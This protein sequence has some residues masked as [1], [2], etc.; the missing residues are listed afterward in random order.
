MFWTVL[1]IWLITFT[2]AAFLAADY[3]LLKDYK[4]PTIIAP[5][6][7][8]RYADGL[9]L[10][11]AT[12]YGIYKAMTTVQYLPLLFPL[13]ALATILILLLIRQPR[14]HL[15]QDG[16]VY[17]FRFIPY[18]AITGMHL[19]DM[20]MLTIALNNGG[21][22]ILSFANIQAVEQA[23]QFFEKHLL[24]TDVNPNNTTSEAENHPNN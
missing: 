18:S 17:Y 1:L 5:A 3:F 4:Q 13:C 15:K 12:A 16:F 2:Y 23:A 7:R 21:K 22:V 9:M 19:S 14:W 24:A 10:L 20:G 6:L 8:R 11:A